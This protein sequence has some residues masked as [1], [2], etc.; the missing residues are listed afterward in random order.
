MGQLGR[1]RK[2]GLKIATTAGAPKLGRAV[3]SG[4]VTF[5]C[6]SCL[7]AQEQKRF[8]GAWTERGREGRRER[9]GTKIATA[10]CVQTPEA[11]AQ[12]GFATLLPRSSEQ[13]RVSSA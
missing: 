2:A 4:C 13:K 12:R 5:Q 10:A 9:A 3:Q 6:H 1:K 11:A 8:L 7:Q